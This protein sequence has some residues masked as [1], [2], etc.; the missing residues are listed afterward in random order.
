MPQWFFFHQLK[1][2]QHPVTTITRDH[3]PKICRSVPLTCLEAPP[4]NICFIFVCREYP[5]LLMESCEV[6]WVSTQRPTWQLPAW[7]PQKTHTILFAICN[8][9]MGVLVAIYVSISC[10]INVSTCCHVCFH[11][12][13]KITITESWE[14]HPRF[15]LLNC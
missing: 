8:Q 12:F 13:F 5:L 3:H 11:M 7:P 9:G 10:H 14:C 15:E 6:F 4:R 1:L 2:V